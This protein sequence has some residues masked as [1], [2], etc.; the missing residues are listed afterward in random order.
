[1]REPAVPT[2]PARSSMPGTRPSLLVAGALALASPASGVHAQEITDEGVILIPAY[3]PELPPELT[4]GPGLEF[5]LTTGVWL[6]RLGGSTSLGAGNP[7]VS[8]EFDTDLRAMETLPLIEGTFR[9]DDALVVRFSGFGFEVDEA[10]EVRNDRQFG[11]LSLDTGD[12]FL[13]ST[14]ISSAAVEVGLGIIEWIDTGGPRY[15]EEVSFDFGP[16]VGF[17]YVDAQQS[18]VID[19]EGS[20]SADGQWA[21]LV[22]GAE[23]RMHYLPQDFPLGRGFGLEAEFGIG[24]AFGGDGGSL[25]QVRGGARWEITEGFDL[26]LGYRLLELD[27]EDEQFD[28]GGGLQGLFLAATFRF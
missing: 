20:E 4:Q 13:G 7:S 12:R 14:E 22:V 16:F 11:T 19:G 23:A 9:R 21:A 17:R 2:R 28:F 5:D 26:L 10:G 24:P 1:M 6:A 15:V 8:L 3:E 27:L 18:F 25:W